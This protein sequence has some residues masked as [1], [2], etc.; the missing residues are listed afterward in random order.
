V[1]TDGRLH[2]G[3]DGEQSKTFHVRDGLGLRLA[4]K[5]GLK[6]GLLS[7]RRN[8]ALKRRAAELEID[9]LVL[10]RSDKGAA[11]AELLAQ[12]RTEAARVAYIGDDLIDLP[13][14]RICGLSFA[15]ADAVQEVRDVVDRVLDQ[16]GGR[17]AAREMVEIVLKARGDWD[18]LLAAFQ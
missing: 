16:P 13:V 5:A 1:L 7:G 4:Q 9:A 12:H 17:G 6:V 14:L 15:P 3:P 2:Y 8:A 11:F 10:N 18:R